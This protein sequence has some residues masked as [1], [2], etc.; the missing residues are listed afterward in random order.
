LIGLWFFV[1]A[2][3]SILWFFFASLSNS[4]EQSFINSL[5][6]GQRLTLVMYLCQLAI[7]ATL[8]FKSDWFARLVLRVQ[9]M[10]L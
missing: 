3:P 7:A 1:E 4:G 9:T 10:E 2:I 5:D 6:E 8:V